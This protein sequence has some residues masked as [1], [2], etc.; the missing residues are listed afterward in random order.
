[1]GTMR[2]G[3][4]AALLA[5]LTLVQGCGGGGGDGGSSSAAAAN[6]AA[7]AGPN[8][9]PISVNAGLGG[10][11]NLA[12]TSVTLCAP[13]NS[14]DCQTIDNVLIDTGSSGLRILS[15]A[16]RA[17]LALP[18]QIDGNGDP[19]VECAHFA[20]GYTWGP[21]K[22]ADFRIA[23]EQ[24]NSLTIQV[25]G[26]PQFSAVPGR[27]SRTGP[28]KNT[29]QQLRANGILGLAIFR[30]DCGPACAAGSGPGIY[31]ACP[32]S[33]CLPVA[34]PLGKQLQNPVSMFASDNNGVII[35]LPSVPEA[36]AVS[37]NGSLVFGIGTQANNAIGG[38]TVIG[39]DA[40]TANFTT[41]LDGNTYS[42]SFI[43]SGSNAFFFADAG[44]PVCT[45][46]AAAGFY[47]PAATKNF[48]ATI[49]G[50]NGKSAAV[51]FSVANA[52]ALVTGN[53]GFAAFGNLAVPE[54][55]AA[56]FDWGLPF[57]Y[58]RSVYT[59]I[60]GASTPVGPGPYVAF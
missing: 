3:L 59:A 51:N 18:Q 19:L 6:P 37:V 33:G 15:S 38:A 5:A 32:A 21:V 43:D 39:V 31:Y 17:S 36:G 14:A 54:L 11:V 16:L 7:L 42:A 57:F 60:D 23:G 1:M 45:D 41:V 12:F 25:I 4:T 26:D 24:A 52:V 46:P 2:N 58:G 8:V 49:E 22:L 47:C 13:G 9:Q 50:R 29:V 56:V 30:Q 40:G 55:G 44:T 20:D 28:P 34:V 10:T 48:S 53:P 27:C 35:K